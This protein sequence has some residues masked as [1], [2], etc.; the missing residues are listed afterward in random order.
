MDKL[1][2]E[3][4]AA[5]AML[6]LDLAYTFAANID[7]LEDKAKEAGLRGTGQ[8]SNNERKA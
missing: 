2:S 4:E 1:L 6:E 5:H 3:N 7:G 8:P